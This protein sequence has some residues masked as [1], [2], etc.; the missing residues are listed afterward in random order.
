M[1]AQSSSPPKARDFALPDAGRPLVMGIVNVTPDS[2]SDGGEFFDAAQAI[3]H[4]RRLADEGADILD[5]GAESTR[6]YGDAKSVSFDEELARSMRAPGA[7][8]GKLPP[9]YPRFPGWEE[10]MTTPAVTPGKL[11]MIVCGDPNRNKVQTLAGGMGGAIQEIRLPGKWDELME[12]AGYRPLGE[13][14][15]R[16]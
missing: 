6:P 15:I 12:E 10:I 1:L 2:F 13:F 3:A 4:A 5:L 7:E 8:K 11:Q 14:S 9:W 16:E